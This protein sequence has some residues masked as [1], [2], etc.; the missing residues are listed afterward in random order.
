MRGEEGGTGQHGSRRQQAGREERG[1][2]RG[3]GEEEGTGLLGSP[4]GGSAGQLQLVTY[5]VRS[6]LSGVVGQPHLHWSKDPP[7]GL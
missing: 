7:R 2:G 1:C 3:K 5:K 4:G 6:G